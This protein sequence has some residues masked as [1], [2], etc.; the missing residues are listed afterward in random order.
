MP[1]TKT[2]SA[3]ENARDA[4]IVETPASPLPTLA[5]LGIFNIEELAKTVINDMLDN[6]DAAQ[7]TVIG[8]DISANSWL[9]AEQVKAG[10]SG[11]VARRAHLKDNVGV[12]PTFSGQAL[13]ERIREQVC[14]QFTDKKNFAL[15]DKI[16]AENGITIEKLFEWYL[17]GVA[18]SNKYLLA[19]PKNKMLSYNNCNQ[20]VIPFHAGG[21]HFN[22]A[23]INF[24]KE[25]KNGAHI[26]FFD[27]FGSDLSESYQNQLKAFIEKKFLLTPSYECVSEG[28]QSDVINCGVFAICKAIDIANENAGNPERLLA[29]FSGAH[30][31]TFMSCKRQ[32]I[33]LMLQEDGYKAPIV[34]SLT[35]SIDTQQKQLKALQDENKE[36]FE[37]V[38]KQLTSTKSDDLLKQCLLLKEK[39]MVLLGEKQQKEAK[40]AN[41]EAEIKLLEK[42]LAVF[43][44]AKAV[45]QEQSAESDMPFWQVALLYA[46]AVISVFMAGA[47]FAAFILP[48]LPLLTTTLITNPIAASVAALT[49]LTVAFFA[50][51][52]IYAEITGKPEENGGFAPNAQAKLHAQPEYTK[53]LLPGFENYCKHD[54]EA[55][56]ENSANETSPRITPISALR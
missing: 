22:V 30:Y 27:S 51:Q 4:V 8:E 1:L 24:N 46:G 56:K 20:Y 15:A 42:M 7:K 38:M 16:L 39:M 10:I 12:Y 41:D 50:C 33:A 26:K 35:A 55:Q 14:A 21:N 31:E 11:F 13:Y 2:N 18:G 3:E 52:F 29:G 28:I 49:I 5:S 45:A 23:V 36:L 17:E 37:S 53:T 43:N 48:Q 54:G 47:L 34:A 40:T 6:L 9:V 19:N 32:E 44:I 25:L